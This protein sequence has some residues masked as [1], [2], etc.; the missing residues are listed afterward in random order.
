MSR[1]VLAVA[2]VAL[3]AGFAIGAASV[4]RPATGLATVAAVLPSDPCPAA[5]PRVP[6]AAV[7]NE[8]R[9]DVT[10]KGHVKAI[11]YFALA[12]DDALVQERRRPLEP[13]VLR[14]AVGACVE[15]S[16]T[17]LLDRPASLHPHLVRFFADSDGAFAGRNADSTVP[18]G[19]TRLYR[20]FAEREQVSFFHTHA[21]HEDVE[22]GLFGALVVEPPGSAFLDPATGVPIASGSQAIVARAGE[23]DFREFVLFF[24]DLFL[25][26]L[27]ESVNYRAE[28]MAPRLASDPNEANVTSSLVHGD[29]IT[30]TL[31][32]YAGD[33]VRLRV[34]G[35][36]PQNFHVFH[37]HAH[38]WLAYS[39]GVSPEPVDSKSFGASEAFTFDLDGGA[40]GP[41]GATGDFLYHCHVLDHMHR[42]MWGLFR[43][44][45]AAEPD[46]VPLPDRAGVGA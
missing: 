19:G 18:P 33:P 35:A 26:G 23:S 1:H 20:W 4:E 3:V 25:P 12:A 6:F 8:L 7:A 45:G 41:I 44:H 39:G 38:Q 24:H 14:V 2:V 5:A 31:R 37:V 17:N 30:P 36:G 13:L 22:A 9:S 21:S 15:I 10:G 11:A 16:L 40:G 42:G 28:L 29:P 46:L 32:A 43:V 34:V 27:V